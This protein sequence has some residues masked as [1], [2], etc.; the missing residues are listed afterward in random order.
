[1]L[2]P[3]APSFSKPFLSLSRHGPPLA[4]PFHATPTHVLL[5]AS[6][7]MTPSEDPAW[8]SLPGAPAPDAVHAPEASCPLP[9]R[10]FP[11]LL[12]VPA[13]IVSLDFSNERTPSDLATFQTAPLR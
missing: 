9:Q 4:L 3:T 10:Y 2:L 12:A 6:V 11:S 5:W 8:N 1:M 13:F 7:P